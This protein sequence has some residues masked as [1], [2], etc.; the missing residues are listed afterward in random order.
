MFQIAYCA[1]HCLQTPGKRLPAALDPG[2][3]RE[4]VLNDRVARHFQE[5]AAAYS[6][7]V[8][9]RTDDPTGS[10]DIPIRQRTEK[11]NAWGADLYL[12]FHHNAAGRVFDGGGVECYSFPGSEE[13]GMY[14]DEIYKAVIAAGG[15]RGNRSD[16]LREKAFDSLR[17]SKM[18][19]VLI[20]FG[21]MDSRVD[22]PII[23]T[24][25]YAKAVAY[26]VMEAVALAADLEKRTPQADHPEDFVRKV[27]RAIGAK[28]DGIPGP[29]TLSK[30]PTVSADKNDTHPV[31]AVLQ[32]RLWAL[33]YTE[34]GAA[35]GIAGPKFTAALTAFQRHNGC[36]AD[37]EATAKNKTWRVL[38]GME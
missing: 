38:L 7:V 32:E 1:G 18:P 4:W 10:T 31:V 26:A 27:Q 5:A 30:T 3:T 28:V 17:Y 2:Q 21:F 23:L 34:V 13:G 37:G 29:E 16:P 14:R 24:D 22:A 9:L 19:A 6:E 36:R 15:I 12:D 25:A 8:L 33:G 11:A 20:E 35:D